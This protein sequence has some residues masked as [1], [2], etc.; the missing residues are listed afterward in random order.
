MRGGRRDCCHPAYIPWLAD[1]F[2]RVLSGPQSLCTSGDDPE[3]ER[4]EHLRVD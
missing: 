1:H 2:L 3:P 4:R